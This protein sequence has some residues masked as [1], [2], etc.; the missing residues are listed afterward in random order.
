M[1]V[2]VGTA[3]WTWYQLT[4]LGPD[5]GLGD[6]FNVGDM[7]SVLSASALAI[8]TRETPFSSSPPLTLLEGN[9]NAMGDIAGFLQ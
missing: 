9:L 1:Q 8:E 4:T 7:G 6:M 5:G 2:Q 3:E